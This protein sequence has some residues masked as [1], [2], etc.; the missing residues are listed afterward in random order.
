MHI[1][2]DVEHTE[3]QVKE[4]VQNIEDKEQRVKQTVE[5]SLS[6]IARDICW[7]RWIAKALVVLNVIIFALK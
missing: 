2:E 4:T 6:T 1:E 7:M 5:E 3:N